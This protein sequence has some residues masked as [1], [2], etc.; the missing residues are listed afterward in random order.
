M[1]KRESN[2]VNRNTAMQRFLKPKVSSHFL[3]L[4][5]DFLMN[6]NERC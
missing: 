3:L 4:T 5:L 6:G 2:R 1:E